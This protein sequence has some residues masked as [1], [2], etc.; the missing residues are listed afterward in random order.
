MGL[1]TTLKKISSESLNLHVETEEEIKQSHILF[2]QMLKDLNQLCEDNGVKWSLCGGSLIGAVRHKGF[3]PWDDDVDIYMS[4]SDFRKFCK[5]FN[6]NEYFLKK[7][8]LKMPGD[9]GYIQHIARLYLKGPEIVPLIST[10]KDEGLPID[11]FVLENTYNNA[12]LRFLHGIQCTFLQFIGA[13]ARA[14]ACRENLLK[15]GKENKR[16][17]R[18]I[19]FWLI[20]ARLF[21]FHTVEQWWAIADKSFSKVKDDSSKYVVSPRGAGHYFGEIYERE[22]MFDIVEVPFEDTNLKILK[23]FDYLLTK[24]FGNDYMT[25]PQPDEIQQHVYV[26]LDLKSN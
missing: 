9:N 6:E 4:R 26:K 10:G 12:I 24:L 15:Y 5:A 13:A 16:L 19:K 11:I 18:E 23:N 22:K 8:D 17:Y 3:I 21:R 1:T 7:Y 14:D 25:V 2:L 20:F